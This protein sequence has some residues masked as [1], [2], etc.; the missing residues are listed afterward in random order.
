MPSITDLASATAAITTATDTALVT[1]TAGQKTR[2][3]RVTLNVDGA[4]I[5]TF[6]SASTQLLKFTAAGFYTL[7]FSDRPWLVTAVNEALNLTTSTTALVNITVEY[8]KN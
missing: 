4:N 2:V 3:H 6:K 8:V 7:N 1:A 5:L